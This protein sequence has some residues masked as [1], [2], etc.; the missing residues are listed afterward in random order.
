MTNQYGFQGEEQRPSRIPIKGGEN[1]GI[2]RL[3]EVIAW[4]DSR[5]EILCLDCANSEGCADSDDWHPLT[6]NDFS[7][8]DVLV[9]CDRCRK[10]SY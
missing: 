7:H 6:E 10:R 1:M 4:E 9:F 8:E 5:G 3:D 2:I